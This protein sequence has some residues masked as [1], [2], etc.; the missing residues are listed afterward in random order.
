MNYCHPKKIIWRRRP[1]AASCESQVAKC[2]CGGSPQPKV[3]ACVT[4]GYISHKAVLSGRRIL[5]EPFRLLPCNLKDTIYNS[6]HRAPPFSTGR[7]CE[8][9]VIGFPSD[10]RKAG[11]AG[12][13][14]GTSHLAG[15]CSFQLSYA[16]TIYSTMARS[17]V[18]RIPSRVVYSHS[19]AVSRSLWVDKSRRYDRTRTPKAWRWRPYRRP[20]FPPLVGRRDS[21]GV[22]ALTGCLS[23][24]QS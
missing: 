8:S 19:F 3:L 6:P 5:F 1:G 24:S 15:E 16:P 12:L 17:A 4:R 2:G 23:R 14:P 10:D 18:T 9:Q 22:P 7:C 21:R 20:N 13:E 11:A